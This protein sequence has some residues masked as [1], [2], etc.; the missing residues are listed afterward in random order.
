MT[1]E[2]IHAIPLRQIDIH[3][4]RPN[5]RRSIPMPTSARRWPGKRGLIPQ[6]EPANRYP[7]FSHIFDGGYSAGYYFYI[8]GP[9][10][11]DKDCFDPL[12]RERRLFDREIAG[13]LPP[14]ACSARRLGRRHCPLTRLLRVR[15]PTR[16][17]CSWPRPDGA[18]AAVDSELSRQEAVPRPKRKTDNLPSTI[19]TMKK[20]LAVMVALC[21]AAAPTSRSRRRS[22]PNWIRPIRC[23]RVGDPLTPRRPSRA[24]EPST[25]TGRFEAAIACSPRPRSTPSSE[26]RKAHFGNTIV[27]LERQ[28]AAA[29]PHRGVFLQPALGRHVGRDG[30]HRPGRAAQSSRRWATTSPSTRRS[31]P[32][33]RRSTSAPGASTPSS[34]CCSR[35]PTAASPATV[36]RSP[37]PTRSYTAVYLR[38]G[39]LTLRF[40]QNALAATNALYAQHH[41]P[42]A[43]GRAPGLRARGSGR[44]RCGPR[45]AGVDRDVQAPSYVPSSPIRPTARS[46]SGCGAPPTPAR[47][48]RVRQRP[49]RRAHRLAASEDRQPAGLRLLCRLR[50]RERM[51]ENTQTVQVVPLGAARRHQGRG[52]RRLP[53]PWPTT[54]GARLAGELMPWDWAYWSEKYKQE[55]Y[56]LSDEVV[57]PTSSSRT[58]SGASSFWPRSSTGSPSRPTPRSRSTT[59]TSR[60]TTLRTPTAASWRCSTSTSSPAPRSAPGRG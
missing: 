44:R 1:T 38:A 31:S 24:I 42:E 17:P 7:Y 5:T 56:A 52:R 50:A 22:C 58:S 2:L 4:H 35:R 20:L 47:W 10:V 55:R 57:S 45:R 40:G 60:P 48:R 26:P 27:A 14:T 49:D 37:T 34:A 23:L 8:R 11:L 12:P 28:G 53:A 3:S 32:A 6:I 25:T 13:P 59:P 51:A 21:M 33:F 39:E 15:S 29:R 41:R 19:A 36:L 46:R 43:C 18:P 9:R 30:A 16:R 54:R